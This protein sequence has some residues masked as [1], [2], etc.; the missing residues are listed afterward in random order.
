MT[1]ASLS[2]ENVSVSR[3]NRRVLHDISIHV[4]SGEIVALLGANGAGKSSLVMTCMGVHH[5]S[6]GAINIDGHNLKGLSP[7]RVR[8]HGVAVV[9]E[10]HRV[11]SKLTVRENLEVAALHLPS[12][13]AALAVDAAIEIFPELKP[14]LGMAAGNLS[15]GQKQMVAIS[16]ALAAQPKILLIDELSL[17]LAPLVIKRLVE[18]LKQIAA[19]GVGIL[20]VEQF[21]TL[22]LS[23]ASRAYLLDLGRMVFDGKA[24]DL[25]EKPEILHRAYLAAT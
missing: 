15:G 8:A 14:H 20:L 18:A 22:A 12:R 1:A 13:Q 10:G 3:G 23:L 7:D 17:G 25:A 16:Q 9:P 6:G 11:L 21:T 24:S 5:A 4:Q 19:D 2:L